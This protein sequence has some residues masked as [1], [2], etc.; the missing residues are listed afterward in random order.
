WAQRDFGVSP[1]IAETVVDIVGKL[2]HFNSPH[3]SH[4]STNDLADQAV[5]YFEG[6]YDIE[7]QYHTLLDG[8]WDHMIDQTHLGYYYWQQPMTNLMPAVNRVQSEK[9]ALAGVMRIIPE[10]TNGAW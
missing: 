1:A 3:C 2:S 7:T 4:L 9:Q 8:K 5:E 6:D 10:G